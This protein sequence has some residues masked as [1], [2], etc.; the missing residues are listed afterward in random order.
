MSS[1]FTCRKY[2]YLLLLILSLTAC[3]QQIKKEAPANLIAE[4]KMGYILADILLLE[5][6]T[7]QHSNAY[8]GLTSNVMTDFSY[9]I[10]DKKYNL[11]DSQFY[12]SYKYYLAQP[13]QMLKVLDYA[14]DTLN[15]VAENIPA[16]EAQ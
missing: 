9:P 6:H 15:K 16:P 5:N 8:I 1:N 2:S 10:I 4:Q 3:T 12:F 14:K 7:M 13:Q 11:A